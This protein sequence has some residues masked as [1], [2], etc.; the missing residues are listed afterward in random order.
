MPL[1]TTGGTLVFHPSIRCSASSIVSD[2]VK[3]FKSSTMLLWGVKSPAEKSTSARSPCWNLKIRA[4]KNSAILYDYYC[5]CLK[6]CTSW[7]VVYPIINKVLY[8]PGGA[9]FQ[10]STVWLLVVAG[11]YGCW[12]LLCLD[13]KPFWPCFFDS[14]KAQLQKSSK[15][16]PQKLENWTMQFL[17]HYFVCKSIEVVMPFLENMPAHTTQ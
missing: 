8:I 12:W 7:K 14:W 13:N 10:P 6:S 2:I 11:D 15:F 17:L 1:T 5:S 4:P 9:R 16:T 3:S